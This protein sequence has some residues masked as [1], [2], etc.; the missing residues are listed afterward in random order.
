MKKLLLPLL[1]LSA[2][3]GISSCSQDF[4]VSAPYK[5]ITVVYSILNLTDTA[6][7]VRIEK[8]FLDEKK[9][10]IVMSKEPDSSYYKDLD[11][12]MQEFADNKVTLLSTT[13]LT[14][15]NLADEGYPKEP[16]ANNQGFFTTPSYAYKFKKTLSPFAWY[17]LLITNKVTGRIDSSDFVGI[18][19]NDPISGSNNF[20]ISQFHN[21]GLTLN[22]SKTG[23]VDKYT[24]TGTTPRN[25]RMLEGH[26]I[27]HYVNKTISTGATEKKQVDFQFATDAKLPTKQFDLTVFNTSVLGFLR[28]EMG[29]AP[30]GV[31]RYMD[32]CEMYVWCGSNELYTYQQVNA[33][34]TGG[35]TADQIRPNYTN[36][37]GSNVLG[38]V[39]SRAFRY[40]D[41]AALDD[42][43]MNVIKTHQ[44]TSTLNIK[45][46][47]DD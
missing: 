29:A 38:V 5:D 37:K 46:R 13:N 6:H 16:A 42:N 9:S 4:K 12:R 8:A 33:G 14:K 7:Y 45:G 39:G 30:T 36:M 2:L 1:S 23:P 31:E 15:V 11:V 10:A 19:N 41:K 27:F 34:Q 35:I 24:L 40:Y 20:F 28:D 43:T 17:R 26:I 22:F 21:A 3:L 47:S 32:S 25:G 18:V 44:L